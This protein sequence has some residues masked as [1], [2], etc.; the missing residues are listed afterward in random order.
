MSAEQ[1]YWDRNPDVKAANFPA[2]AHY[3]EYGKNEGR[4]WGTAVE[5]ASAASL[6]PLSAPDVA[7][8]VETIYKAIKG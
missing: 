1:A 6:V 7:K 5:V 2:R 8:A 3:D 4:K